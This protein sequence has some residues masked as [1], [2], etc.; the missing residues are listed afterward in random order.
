MNRHRSISV[1]VLILLAALAGR[2][3][4]ASVSSA[5]GAIPQESA[6]SLANPGFEGAFTMRTDPYTGQMAPELGVAEGW[7]LWYDN[8]QVTPLHV[9]LAEIEAPAY[10]S[11]DPWDASS[12]NLRPEYKEESGTFRVRTGYKAQKFFTTYGTHTAGFYQTVQVPANSWVRFSIWVQTWSS[13]LDDPEHS[14][15]PGFYRASVGID[16]TGGTAWSSSN[17][18]WS[19]PVVQHDEWVRLEVAAFTSSGNISVWTRGAPMWP[20]KHNDSYW[21]D[22]ALTL[23]DGPPPPTAA[24][25]P[26]PTAYRTPEPTPVGYEPH[27]PW[28]WLAVWISRLHQD[29]MAG[30]SCD[31]AQGAVG[32]EDAALWLRNAGET[33]SFPLAWANIAWPEEEDVRVSFRFAFDQHAGFG[34]TIGVGSDS[35]SGERV[36][37]GEDDLPQIENILSISHSLTPPEQPGFV[38][39]LLGNS[40]PVWVGTTGDSAWHVAQLEL[41]G[42][43]YVLFVDGREVGRGVSYWRPQS[44]YVGNPVVLPWAGGWTEVG[45][46]DV[47]VQ[48]ADESIR[49]PIVR[50][51]YYAV[52]VGTLPAPAGLLPVQ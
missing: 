24:P 16:P 49:L 14:F 47:I 37:M 52:S 5:N 35:Y 26:S 15:D 11:V 33:S 45:I 6:L 3:A 50:R 28:H 25:T 41:R 31:Q 4:S 1:L 42:T 13:Q 2:I 17:I 27:E 12:Y 10:L 43:T 29:S 46:A 30:W 51:D 7:Y 20:V 18:V 19:E 48:E 44:L 38:I 39:R 21:D 34:T 23:L 36:L 40:D 9:T 22:A 32:I 8:S